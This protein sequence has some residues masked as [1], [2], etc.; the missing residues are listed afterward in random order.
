ML[1]GRSHALALLCALLAAGRAGAQSFA[2]D[3]ELGD[4]SRWASPVKTTGVLLSADAAAQH[5]G[6]YGFRLSDTHVGTG[7]DV[8][9]YVSFTP[10]VTQGRYYFRCW[11]RINAAATPGTIV[12]V[13]LEATPESDF[14]SVFDL[15]VALPSGALS[16]AGFDGKAQYAEDGTSRPALGAWHLVEG[17]LLGIQ[18]QLGS[19][20]LWVDGVPVV[21]GPARDLSGV[22]LGMVRLGEPYAHD[23]SYSGQ[24][25]VDDFRAGSAPH[26]SRFVLATP[27]GTSGCFPVTVTLTDSDGAPAPAPYDVEAEL[28]LT[29]VPAGLFADP[30]CT[31]PASAARVPSGDQRGTAYLLAQ[32][33]GTVRVAASH[34]DF[35]PGEWS[36]EVSPNPTGLAQLPLRGWSCDVAPSPLTAWLLLALAALR[37]RARRTW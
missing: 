31:T 2:D 15:E 37:R 5:R 32:S 6:Q 16:I 12:I 18:G 21:T 23:R 14:T 22:V 27:S 7:E 10:Q 36:G 26:A 25:D 28:T 30:A 19:R 1:A 34:Q 3:F 17:A 29:G 4:L 13:E 9:S 33:A 8:E 11:L 24:V 20:R 35:L